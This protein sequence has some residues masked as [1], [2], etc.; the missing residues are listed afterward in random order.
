MKHKRYLFSLYLFFFT[1]FIGNGYTMYASKYLGEM[2]L[3]NTQIG[4]TTAVPAFV[5]IFAQPLWGV[6]ADRSAKKR[7]AVDAA[8]LACEQFHRH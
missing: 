5:A 7:T 4:L 2:G 3:T 8:R 1:L 6:I